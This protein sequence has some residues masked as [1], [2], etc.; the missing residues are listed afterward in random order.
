ME[1]SDVAAFTGAHKHRYVPAMSK[2]GITRDH[3][4]KSSQWFMLVRKHAEEVVNDTVVEAAF[5]Y[6]LLCYMSANIRIH[7]CLDISRTARVQRLNPNIVPDLPLI[8]THSAECFVRRHGSNSRFC[9]SDEHY[10]PTL[11]A[12]RGRQ[13]ET[14]C[15]SSAAFTRWGGRD[16]SHP[17]TFEAAAATG[18]ALKMMRGS[19]VRN[20]TDD[21]YFLLRFA[22]FVRVTQERGESVLPVRKSR[23]VGLGVGCDWEAGI[24]FGHC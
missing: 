24:V 11:L 2:F 8:H 1:K 13:N 21:A 5:R 15:R 18:E 7:A 19:C 23:T 22:R 3:W 6:V 20:V 10:I 16:L 4:M 12:F 14:S 17:K 9:V